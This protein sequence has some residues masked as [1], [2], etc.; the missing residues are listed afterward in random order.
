M[1]EEEHIKSHE[2]VLEKEIGGYR[3]FY[4]GIAEQL[5]KLGISIA[6]KP[7][8]H[9]GYKTA[10]L[11]SYN[12]IR[13]RIMPLCGEYLENE[14]NGRPIL[15]AILK[16][17]LQLATDTEVS[18]VELMP[19]KPDKHYDDGL[20]HLGVVLGKDLPVFIEQHRSRIDEIQDQ[21]PYCKPACIVLD[22][23]SRVKFYEYSLRQA[24]EMEGQVFQNVQ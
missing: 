14:H 7:L 15:K 16:T 22:D 4:L 17:P 20:E 5:E 6:G 2:G 18:M 19:P 13:N 21:G 8:S 23:G 1:S 11:E 12:E 10:T 24:I 9:L 3:Q